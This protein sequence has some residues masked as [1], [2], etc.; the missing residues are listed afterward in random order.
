MDLCDLLVIFVI[1]RL[2]VFSQRRKTE[3]ERLT[4]ISGDVLR[5]NL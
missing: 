4:S 3:S 1:T 5:S 2:F